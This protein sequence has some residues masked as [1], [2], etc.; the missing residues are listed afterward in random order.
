L[1]RCGH[2][3]SCRLGFPSDGEPERKPDSNLGPICV[4]CDRI[5][6]FAS[7]PT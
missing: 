5:P 3:G 7:Y 2:G 4:N 6:A 1:G